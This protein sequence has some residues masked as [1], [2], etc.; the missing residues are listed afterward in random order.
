MP[1]MML[2]NVSQMMPMPYTAAAPPKPMMAEV[3]MKVAP[4]EMAMIAG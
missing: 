4:Y 3:E 2:R 1:T